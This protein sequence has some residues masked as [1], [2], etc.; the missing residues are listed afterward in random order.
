M[1]PRGSSLTIC[2]FF[3]YW[4]RKQP[5]C[6]VLSGGLWLHRGGQHLHRDRHHDAQR[7]TETNTQKLQHFTCNRNNHLIKIIG[8]WEEICCTRKSDFKMK[9]SATFSNFFLADQTSNISATEIYFIS[10]LYWT[11]CPWP[12]SQL[13]QVDMTLWV[14]TCGVSCVLPSVNCHQGVWYAAWV[15]TELRTHQ[16]QT[17]KWRP[18]PSRRASKTGEVS[19]AGGEKWILSFYNLVVVTPP[20]APTA[21]GEGQHNGPDTV[22]L[23]LE[24]ELKNTQHTT[25]TYSPLSGQAR[26]V[27]IGRFTVTIYQLEGVAGWLFVSHPVGVS[28]SVAAENEDHMAPP[29]IMFQFW[30]QFKSPLS[31]QSSLQPRF[32]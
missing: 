18:G 3:W 4:Q 22:M 21:T 15:S 26:K 7:H 14:M 29:V 24:G 16:L 2:T 19:R 1:D 13:I 9:A 8:T 28:G 20:P 23:T 32:N 27:F 30:F 31:S 5:S 10:Y 11:G 6:C 12:N 17:Y 25:Q